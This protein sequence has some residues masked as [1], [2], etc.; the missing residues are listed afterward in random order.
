MSA[1]RVEA[2][3]SESTP[4]LP[5]TNLKCELI[6]TLDSRSRLNRIA[7]SLRLFFRNLFPQ[8]TTR[9]M[10]F[11]IYSLRLQPVFCLINPVR[12]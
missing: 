6:V 12:N 2:S 8:A 1:N 11:E 10:F 7:F 4:A 3:D 5:L 9:V